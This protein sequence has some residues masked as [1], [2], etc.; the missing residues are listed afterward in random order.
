MQ[1][2]IQ[3]KH[4]HMSK[5]RN[6]QKK[7]CET[8]YEWIKGKNCISIKKENVMKPSSHKML[9]D[10]CIEKIFQ[11]QFHTEIRTFPVATTST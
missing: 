7:S 5:E 9:G 1:F 6:Q 2:P 11:E 4:M 3:D 10:L 8:E